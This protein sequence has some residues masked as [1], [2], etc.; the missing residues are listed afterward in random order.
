M[1]SLQ[2]YPLYFQYGSV[3]TD[4][5]STYLFYFGSLDLYCG[6]SS[7]WQPHAFVIETVLTL[8]TGIGC[9]GHDEAIGQRTA[10]RSPQYD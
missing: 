4:H 5:A 10:G 6:I 8:Q 3:E 7:P 9:H 1:S 2:T